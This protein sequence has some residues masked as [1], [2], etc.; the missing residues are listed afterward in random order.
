MALRISKYS[1]LKSSISQKIFGLLKNLVLPGFEGLNLLF[2]LRFFITGIQKGGIITRASAISF[3]VMLAIIPTLIVLLTVIPYIPIENFQEDLLKNIAKLMPSN[4]YQLF[5]STIHDLIN[6]KHSTF[7]S[8]GF[9]LGLYY[10]SNTIM[11]ILEGFRSSYHLKT[12]TEKNWK[13][14]ARSVMLLPILAILLIITVALI[15]L[16][17]HVLDY[18][19][20]VEI[21]GHNVLLVVLKFA[22]WLLVAFIFLFSISLLYNIGDIGKH[23]W[24][25]I[26]AGATLATISFII[27]SLGFAWYVN[28]FGNYNQLY[29]SVGTVLVLLL[30]VYFNCI[31]LLVGF[32]LNTSIS[33]AK[34]GF[35]TPE[36]KDD[37]PK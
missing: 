4:A 23:K 22:S 12:N 10:S 8:I 9:V 19:R 31:I 5:E 6:K 25:T 17:S 34:K 33:R 16:S 2:V 28:N 29:G 18:L 35:L 7:L 3:K 32:E 26:S 30:W 37:R 1:I 11:A 14:R 21:I 20:E 13:L 36:R 27:V 24:K 15:T